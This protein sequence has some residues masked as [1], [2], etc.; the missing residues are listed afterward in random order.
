[1]TLAPAEAGIVIHALARE[2]STVTSSARSS[3]REQGVTLVD[4]TRQWPLPTFPAGRDHRFFAGGLT[5]PDRVLAPP[6]AL[7]RTGMVAS[8]H[9]LATLAG[10]EML[11]AGG[12]VADAAVATNAVLAVTQPNYCGVGGD[13]FCLYYEAATRRV[14]FLNGAG[15][16][17][18]RA[19]LDELA[20][21]RAERPA[22][23]SGPATVSVPGV[24]A[25]VGH[26]ARAL[27]HAAARR[28]LAPAIHYAERGFPITSSLSQ[29]HPE[30][31]PGN[32]DPEWRRVFFAGGRAPRR[33]TLFVQPDLA[34]TLRDLARRGPRPLLSRARGA[35]DRRADGEPTAS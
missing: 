17:G 6:V 24:H 10:V 7:G 28:L 4:G 34:R 30:Y 26:A 8:C 19:T 31:A 35:G 27:R 9:P 25:G 15:R 12:T 2:R 16:S 14:H 33:A 1:M 23:R 18:S 11:K 29:A 20:A 21:P 5:C 13:L 32:P 22:R 3:P